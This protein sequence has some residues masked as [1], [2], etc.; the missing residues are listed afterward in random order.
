MEIIFAILLVAWILLYFV[1]ASASKNT[2]ISKYAWVARATKG[3]IFFGSFG[4]FLIAIG[5]DWNIPLIENI[6]G[7][8]CIMVGTIIF[9][10]TYLK[11]EQIQKGLETKEIKPISEG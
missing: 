1:E 10:R 5:T 7:I 8:I 4:V 6:I 11:R 9:I 3:L 2:A